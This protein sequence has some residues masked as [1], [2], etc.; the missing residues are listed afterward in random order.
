MKISEL[1][2]YKSN[3]LYNKAKEIFDVDVKDKPLY[4]SQD[5]WRTIM[6]H[7]GFKHL[8]S[9][10]YGSA[11][12]HPKYPWVFKIFKGDNSYFKF[13]NYARRN[14]HNPNLPKIKGSYIRIGNDAYVVRL[15]K[16]QEISR[17][18]YQKVEEIINTFQ[19]I[20]A[21]EKYDN[22]LTPEE[23]QLLKLYPGIHEF[24]SALWHLDIFSTSYPDLHGGNI[25]MRGDV[26][27]IIDPVVD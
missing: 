24:L 21:D 20:I 16:L 27:V 25:M 14:Q 9:G 12:E 3:E 2:G 18:Q 10:S 15:E 19:D 22:E 1:T 7:Y 13:F 6:E 4:V 8:G 17:E 26:P 23:K 11:Y 5:E